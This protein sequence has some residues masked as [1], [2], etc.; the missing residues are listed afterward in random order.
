MVFS[1]PSSPAREPGRSTRQWIAYIGAVVLPFVCTWVTIRTPSFHT[2]PYTLHFACI[3]GLAALGGLGPALAAIVVSVASFNYHLSAPYDQWSFTPPHFARA[4]ALLAA[5]FFLIFISW[6]QRRTEARLRAALASLQWQTDALV[7][8]EKLAA[9]GRLASTIAHEVNN[10]LESVTNLLY[11]ARNGDSIDDTTR[12]YLALAEEE[13][14][15]L[16][17][18]TRLTLTFVRTAAVRAPVDLA[19]TLDS[20]LSIFR[21]RCELLDLTVERHYTPNLRID[22][23]EH[24]LRQV[25]TNLISN[26]IDA[27]GGIGV[28]FGAGDAASPCRLRVQ[29]FLRDKTVIL[30]VEDNGRGIA[31]ADQSRVF[32]AFFSTKSDTGTGIGLWVTRE[33][34]EKN[35]GHISVR[36]GNLPHGMRTR[37]RLEL[38]AAALT[39]EPTPAPTTNEPE[40]QPIS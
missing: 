18:I 37:F 13:L 3:A 23:F 24:E 19:A 16:S 7:R 38:P 35:A 25:L 33:L 8:A 28:G 29:T 27:L 2:I 21:R 14:A 5:A 39:P 17:N 30:H 31:E 4:S 6:Q 36:S 22:I 10:P 26:A 32:D 9:M 1:P 20:V 15:R 40:S 34:V 12:S 11:L